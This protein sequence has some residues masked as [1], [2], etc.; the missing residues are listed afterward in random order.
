MTDPSVAGEA[1]RAAV[2]L[3]GR[4]GFDE[5][6]RGRVALV[7]T[8]AATN[9]AKHA[10]GGEIVIQGLEDGPVG[11]LD[12]L[13]LDRGPGMADVAR[14]LADGYSTAGSSGT[15]LGAVGRLSA[16]FDIHSLPGV[17][18]TLLARLWASP[19]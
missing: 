16:R 7:A 17:G 12:V 15:G 10:R 18:S 3:A 19:R 9:L 14:C 1:R 13:A 5:T 6:A 11:G 2:A 8:E 4:L